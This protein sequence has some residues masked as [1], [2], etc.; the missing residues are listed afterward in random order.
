MKA[1]TVAKIQKDCSNQY[2]K[3]D[4]LNTSTELTEKSDLLDSYM[5]ILVNEIEGRVSDY[6]QK[7][8]TVKLQSLA[9]TLIDISGSE[10]GE[11]KLGDQFVGSLSETNGIA[12]IRIPRSTIFRLVDLMFGGVATDKEQIRK[13]DISESEGYLQEKHVDLIIDSV[14]SLVSKTTGK[15]DKWIKFDKQKEASYQT[16]EQFFLAKMTIAYDLFSDELELFL[17]K[18]IVENMLGLSGKDDVEVASPPIDC[19]AI[20]QKHILECPVELK[21]TLE[22]IETVF[23][24]VEGLKKG[25]YIP[26]KTL[27]RATISVENIPMINVEMG[28]MDNSVSARFVNWK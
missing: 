19:S 16:T 22:G 14:L 4:L 12:G 20:L 26:L 1:K 6:L 5:D 8:I 27:E 7:P 3:I 18:N 13:F 25:S 17:S 10:K 2:S 11:E 28:E 15:D 9:S 21:C 24:W 23:A